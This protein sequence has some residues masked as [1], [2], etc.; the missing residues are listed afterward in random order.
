MVQ[1]EK[2]INSNLSTIYYRLQNNLSY[3]SGYTMIY[4]RIHYEP[5]YTF[6]YT[7]IHHHTLAWYNRKIDLDF[8]LCTD[9]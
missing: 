8:G 7:I 6:G 1:S 2:L 5:Y 9:E 3:T 4:S